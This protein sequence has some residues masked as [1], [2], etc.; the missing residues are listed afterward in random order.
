MIA[1][2]AHAI[3]GERERLL[4]A[5]MDDYLSK[6]IEEHVLHQALVHWNPYAEQGTI[7]KLDLKES[8]LDSI[9]AVSTSQQATISC[10]GGSSIDWSTALKQAANKEALAKDMLQML[11]EFLPE[12]DQSIEKALIEPNE[13]QNQLLATIHKLH[14]SC[15]YSGVPKLQTLCATIETALRA[16]QDLAEIEPELFELQDEMEKVREDSK[17]YLTG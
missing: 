9:P 10:L 3:D 5:G 15:A 17:Q 11:I 6:P 12:V 2:T 8:Q 13:Q 14:G 16:E 7:E 1:V 4:Q